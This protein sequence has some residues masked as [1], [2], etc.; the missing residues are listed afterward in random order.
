MYGM[1]DEHSAINAKDKEK[2][3]RIKM[4]FRC[5]PKDNKKYILNLK[6]QKSYIMFVSILRLAQ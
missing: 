4:Y 1:V 3:I 6:R 2:V 5:Y